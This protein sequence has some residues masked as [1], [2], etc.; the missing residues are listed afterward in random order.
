VTPDDIAVD[1]YVDSHGHD[2]YRLTLPNGIRSTVSS[3][4]L[5]DERKA[6]LLRTYATPT[7]TPS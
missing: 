7:P 2:C 6:Q 5:I 4:H 3:A 1:Y